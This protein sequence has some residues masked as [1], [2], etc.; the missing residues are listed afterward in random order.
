MATT[1]TGDHEIP[2]CVAIVAMGSSHK[3]YVQDCLNA[4]SRWKVA[5]ETWAINACAGVLAHDRAFIMDRLSYFRQA[6]RDNKPLEGYADW[7]HLHKGPIYTS[8]VEPE[9]PGS[10]LYPLDEVVKDLGFPYFNSTPAYALAYAIHLRVKTVK[11][12]GCDY[13][14]DNTN[15]GVKG[16]ACME[17]WIARAEA[18]GVKIWLPSTTTLCDQST[19]R[20]LYGYSHNPLTPSKQPPC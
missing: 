15:D 4:S 18:V 7:L 14:Y 1:S 20:V 6:A 13:R 9:F 11:I 8:Q 5:D 2:R 3:E 16:R 17:Y 19:G 10:V 12:Y